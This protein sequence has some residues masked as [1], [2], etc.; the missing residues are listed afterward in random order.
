MIVNNGFC[1]RVHSL[2]SERYFCNRH[3]RDIVVF[4]EEG[5]IPHPSCSLCNMLVPWRAL[6]GKHHNTA[7]CR[8]GA[9]R[10]RQKMVDTELRESTEMSFED[11]GKQLE[12]VHSFKYLGRITTAGDEDWPAVAGNMAKAQKSWGRLT[13]ILSREG[14][15][16]RISGTFFKA[17]V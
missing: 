11:Y 3:V 14:A 7:M 5:N 9:K 1:L 16:K 2:D 12:A 8:S 6:N 17:V 10:K 13:R 4:L 15:E